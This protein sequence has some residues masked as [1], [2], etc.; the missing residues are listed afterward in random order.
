MNANSRTSLRFT[1][2]ISIL[3]CACA[4]ACLL[5]AASAHGADKPLKYQ[6]PELLTGTIYAKDSGHQQVLFK[7]KRVAKRSGASLSVLREYTYPDGK[8]AAREQ[9]TYRGDDLVSYALEEL[10]C[11]SAGSARLQPNPDNPNKGTLDFEYRPNLAS[12][13]RPK[14]SSESLRNHTINSDMVA[15]F[16]TTHWAELA[17][18]SKV[19]CRYLVVP[20]RETVGFTFVKDSESTLQGKPVLIIRMEATSPII[21]ALV[22]PVLFTVEAGGKHRL[23]QYVG[24]VT[25][26]AKKGDDWVDLDAVAV[27]DWPER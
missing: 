3:A 15:T 14:T 21:A 17:S 9:V 20:R 27:Y 5:V 6:D 1:L 7:F 18:G 26:K 10:Q 19:R 25:P 8:V 24:R 22:D 4:I 13:I 2:P 23:L 11:G 12:T 16:L